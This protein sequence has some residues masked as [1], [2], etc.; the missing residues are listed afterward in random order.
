MECP[1]DIFIICY[2]LSCCSLS[3][4]PPYKF[5][6]KRKDSL[7]CHL[8]DSCLVYVCEGISCT[9]ET[10]HDVLKFT[11]VTEFLAHTATMHKYDVNIKLCH[12]PKGPSLIHSDTSSIDSAEA[13]LESVSRLGTETPAS[14]VG[15]ETANLDP[16]LLES[17]IATI[18]KPLLVDHALRLLSPLALR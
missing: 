13:P 8:I 17:N 1:T 11:Q 12:L 15:F 10:C 18:T 9:W 7:Y 4:P 3:N 14:S 6:A 16:R 2:G 5:P